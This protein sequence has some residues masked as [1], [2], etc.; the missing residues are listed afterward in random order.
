MP[1]PGFN[2]VVDLSH[3]NAL[4]DWTALR[5]AGIAAV[6]H[7]ATEG[8]TFRD[9]AFRERRDKARAAGLLWGSYHFSSGRPPADQVA[10]YLEW[11]DPA[12]DEL[13]CLDYEPS[14]SG[15]TMTVEAMVEFVER[16]EAATGRLPVLYGGHL[17]REAAAEL[18]ALIGVAKGATPRDAGARGHAPQAAAARAAAAN[19]NSSTVE[20]PADENGPPGRRA[21]ATAAAA[22]LARCPLWY[23]RY[24]PAP[25]GIPA[26]WPRWTLWQYTDGKAGPEP[27]EVPGLG[28]CDRD[29]FNGTEAELRARWPL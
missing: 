7:K 26:L 2:G 3:H 18:D 13:I 11:A 5:R 6:I 23:A 17:I 19:D 27:H 28:P 10:N 21:T 24:A 14:T 29:T 16:I 4:A 20:R 1:V 25:I 8:A 9:K 15:A 22:V 12:D